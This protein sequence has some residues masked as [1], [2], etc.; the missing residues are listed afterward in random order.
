MALLRWNE[1][2]GRQLTVGSFWQLEW[3]ACSWDHLTKKDPLLVWIS[4]AAW[5]EHKHADT[6]LRLVSVTL[7]NL[8]CWCFWIITL[9]YSGS[10]WVRRKFY[11]MAY[12]TW[13]FSWAPLKRCLS[14]WWYFILFFGSQAEFIVSSTL[15]W[16]NCSW[17]Q[18]KGFYSMV[19]GYL[20]V[21]M[22]TSLEAENVVK[23]L[24]VSHRDSLDS[25]LIRK[26]NSLSLVL[27]NTGLILWNRKKNY[28]PCTKRP[29]DRWLC[30]WWIK[31]AEVGKGR[32]T[33]SP[34]LVP[35]HLKAW[36]QTC[37]KSL[38]AVVCDW[39]MLVLGGNLAG[40]TLGDWA[41]PAMVLQAVMDVLLGSIF[42]KLHGSIGERW[43]TFCGG[44]RQ[45]KAKVQGGII[46]AGCVR[47]VG[48]L[49]RR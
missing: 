40:M 33:G 9:P 23:R 32:R 41:L 37:C 1:S 47:G 31:L 44:L 22:L 11:S 13:P 15:F 34:Q 19:R 28:I 26:R 27:N 25:S 3:G 48:M 30:A 39:L 14:S 18:P 2:V 21:N 16:C 24:E 49:A 20:V 4:S 17:K 6:L 10:L 42:Q 38:W 29:Q 45:L 8:M 35:G 7:I 43:S 5:M 36:C 12:G 46:A